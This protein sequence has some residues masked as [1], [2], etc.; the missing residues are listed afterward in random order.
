MNYRDF[1]DTGLKVSEIGFGAWGIGGPAMAG[2]IPI[3]WGDVDDDTS[4][5]ALHTAFE[6]GINFYDTAD[7]YGLGH[8]EELIGKVFGNSDDVIIAS[9]VGHRL[10]KDQS[11]YVDYSCQYII[12]ACEDSLRRLQRD[13]IDYYQLH[14]AKKDDLEKGECIE[15]LEQLKAAGKIRFWG[16]SLNTFEPEPEAHYMLSRGLGSG[17]QLVYN[18]LNQIALPIL[19]QAKEQKKGVIARMPLQ[20]GL[21]TGKFDKQSRFDANDHRHFRLS[22]EILQSSLDALEE[23]WPLTEK[24]GLSK[25]ELSLS[26]ILS[27]DA[28][29]TVIPGIKTPEQARQNTNN[30]VP[31]LAEDRDFIST[32][33]VQKFRPIVQNMQ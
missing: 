12:K 30:I 4:I 17:F 33:F 20:F 7:F 10:A 19:E 16:L 25:T 6:Q 26:Y 18:I 2:D 3:G 14:T 28:I 32:C 1:G 27:F 8:S 13:S 11:I 23:I 21:L 22:P 31:L 15:A 29:S 24:Y 9:K 5:Q